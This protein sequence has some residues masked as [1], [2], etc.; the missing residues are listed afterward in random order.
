[1]TNRW[2]EPHS[3]PLIIGHRGASAH[4][5]ENTLAAFR[6]ARA[7]GADGVELDT[8]R[9][10]SGEVVIMHDP[11]LE[12]TTNGRGKVHEWKLADLRALDAGQGER[13]PTLDEVFE[14]LDS[15]GLVNV[16]VTNYTTPEDGLETAVVGVVRRHNIAER[17]LFSTFNPLSLRRLAELAPDIPRAFLYEP[18]TPAEM[19]Q[20]M[21]DPSGRALGREFD[22]PH[23]SLVTPEFV[24]EKGARGLLVNTWTVNAAD[25]IRRVAACGVRGIIGDSPLTMRAALGLA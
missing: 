18:E 7:Q 14:A 17:I 19:H 21:I 9:C 22:H 23:F 4:A 5:P 3:R 1:M 13:V 8:K 25:E 16:E 10:A 15:D 12:R 6:M 2:I 24:Q 20:L 11:T